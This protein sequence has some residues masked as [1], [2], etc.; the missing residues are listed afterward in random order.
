[1]VNI[2]RYFLASAQELCSHCTNRN[3][4]YEAMK[5]VVKK[6]LEYKHAIY[7]KN[8][9]GNLKKDGIGTTTVEGLSQKLCQTLPNHRSRTLVKIVIRWKLHDAYN[10]LR[11]AQHENTVTWRK[12]KKVIAES[13]MLNEFNELWRREI[14]K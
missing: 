5:C 3:V 10:E 4:V 12:E 14:T 13:G 7:V 1:M 8:L 2:S 9:Y 11:R 6:S